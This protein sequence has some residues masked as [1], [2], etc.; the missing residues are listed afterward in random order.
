MSF[1][2]KDFKNPIEETLEAAANEPIRSFTNADKA[3]NYGIELEI[4]K[5]LGFISSD[6]ENF[7][8]IGNASFIHSKVE[9]SNN[10]FQQANRA[11]QGQAP[12]ILNLGLYYDNYNLG[13]NASLTYNKVGQRISKVGTAQLGNTLEK[14]VDL[15]DLSVS[16]TLFDLFTL[17]LA[18]KDLLNQ[19]RLQI[20]QA[21]APYGDIVAERERMGRDITIGLSYKL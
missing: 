5:S 7:S 21:P 12:Y 14:P 16:K 20:Q 4:R 2:Y 3:T 17:K 13:F 9:I 6:F 18:I 1:F 11:L 10:L 8:F 15:I 19:D